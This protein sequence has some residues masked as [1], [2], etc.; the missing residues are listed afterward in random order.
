MATLYF[1]NG[2]LNNNWT[3]TGVQSNW[4][5][6]DGGA[7][8]QPIPTSSDDVVFTGNSPNCIVNAATVC[9]CRTLAFT[10]PTTT[11]YT[12]TITMNFNITVGLVGSAFSGDVTL[13]S[14]FTNSN[15]SGSGA[16]VI[17]V[18]GTSPDLT[19]NGGI[20]NANIIVGGGLSISFVDNWTINS[21]TATAQCTLQTGQISLRGDL[22][23]SNIV[24][25]SSLIKFIGT[26]GQIWNHTGAVNLSNSVTIDKPSGVLTLGANI[27]YLTGT[28]TFVASGGTVDATTNSNEFF[29]N[30]S[31][32]LNT[33]GI[34]WN[35]VT[36]NTGTITLTLTSNF[37]I[38][39]TFWAV[40]TGTLTLSITTS[41]GA[42]FL[43]T[44]LFQ[45][46][47]ASALSVLTITITLPNDI[48]VS[49]FSMLDNS[50]SAN[51]RNV[52][53][54]GNRNIFISGNVYLGNTRA[55]TISGTCTLVP[56]GSGNFTLG[57]LG[58]AFSAIHSIP[59]NFS[60]NYTLVGNPVFTSTTISYT[61]GT[62]TG[63]SCIFT[64]CTL[65]LNS[66]G[67]W[68][69]DANIRGNTTLTSNATFGN[70]TTSTNN[71][72]FT[73]SFT[74]NVK[75]NL[76][77]D[78]A[79]SGVNTSFEINGTG[80]QSW[81]H[82]SAVY[83]SNPITI[84]KASGTLTLGANTYN[85]G[86]FTYTQGNVDFTTNN[87]NFVV[88]AGTYTTNGLR[89][90]TFFFA[91]NG[92]YAIT[93]G[94][95]L[96]A[97][98]F[99]AG[100]NCT[101]NG[102]FDVYCGT[103]NIN[104]SASGGSGTVTYARNFYCSGDCNVSVL[105]STATAYIGGN[106]SYANS[107]AALGFANLYMIGN[108]TL[109]A[110]ATG[111]FT[112][113]SNLYINTS[114]KIKLVGTFS[115]G[116]DTNTA[117]IINLIRGSVD[118]SKATIILPTAQTHTLTNMNKMLGGNIVINTSS[119][120]VTLTMN[121]FFCGD[122]TN[123]TNITTT[124]TTNNAIV[125]FTDNFEKIAKFVNMNGVTFTKPQQLILI[126]NQPKKTRNIGI[127]Y[128]NQSPNGLAKNEPSVQNQM[129][130]STSKFLLGDPSMI[131]TI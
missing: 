110:L 101:I 66:G 82:G 83:I 76:T 131:K 98:T 67:Q 126:T 65:N 28:L 54:N 33:N 56:S 85:S 92:S 105:K 97:N 79:T 127:R 60:G 41:G 17:N 59:I 19:S 61:S 95:D 90:N 3:Q 45:V 68:G 5:L 71:V 123:Q 57:T 75:G 18:T 77:I 72:G 104:N 80:N 20:W 112:F 64:T 73:G 43:P 29:I 30:G 113:P 38:A 119:P 21:L 10:T 87:N 93:L 100:G 26:G 34:N 130:Y 31:C 121:E 46:N 96:S 23:I 103:L 37:N 16:L 7:G 9:V 47:Y 32:T 124:S 51:K 11:N 69:T 6:S 50:G 116:N 58:G 111:N 99:T 128:G 48:N 74:I 106:C 84:N 25:G 117:A 42:Q 86:N 109:T 27:Y 24:T 62:I 39:G 22:T 88:I 63:A 102:S 120:P 35:N 125:T 108:G 49:S 36:I 14:G 81:T 1:V 107:G 118:A 89:F 2:G 44:G 40:G 4:S 13:H 53:L 122:A 91:S 70:L 129:T 94:S 55:A 52:V 78:I 8:G 15:V 115:F 114:G 12:N